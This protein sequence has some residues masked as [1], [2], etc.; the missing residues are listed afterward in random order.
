MSG[1]EPADSVFVNGKA[2]AVKDGLLSVATNRAIRRYIGQNTAVDLRGRIA[3][4]GFFD[5]HV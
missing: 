3:T 4:P 5:G 1:V 2:F